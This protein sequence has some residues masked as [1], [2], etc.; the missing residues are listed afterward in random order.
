MSGKRR[1]FTKEFKSEIV[2]FV[3]NG[4]RSVPDVAREYDLVE[5][6]V[7]SWVK[8]ARVDSG[9][10][11]AGALMSQEKEEL[12]RLKKENREL[13]RERD[14]LSQATAFFAKVKR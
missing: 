11:P 14:F 5:T 6:C 1:K 10:G 12:S 4:G 9:N 7:Y 13:R 8:Q 3:R 2:N